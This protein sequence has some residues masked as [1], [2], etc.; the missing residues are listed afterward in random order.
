MRL[1][2]LLALVIV[3]CGIGA[4]VGLWVVKNELRHSWRAR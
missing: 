1:I 3:T 4:L 2:A